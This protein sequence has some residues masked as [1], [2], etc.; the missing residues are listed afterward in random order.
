MTVTLEHVAKTYHDGANEI[1][2]VR[3]ASLRIENGKFTII[4]GASG[5]GK[6]TLLNLIG[7]IDRPTSGKIC[8]GD[9]DVCEASDAELDRVRARHIGY[10]FQSFNLIPVL[11]VLENVEF[12][13]RKTGLSSQKQRSAALEMLDAVGL[14]GLEQKRPNQLSGGQRQRVAIARALTKRPTVVLA[15]EPTANLDSGTGAAILDLMHDLQRSCGIS[16]VFSTHD[17]ALIKRAD[18]LYVIRDG[19]IEVSH[20]QGD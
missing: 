13:L 11:S 9:T 3:D 10:I 14:R 15:D 2:A 12:S 7:C 5:S 8:L 6:S 18:A 1:H 20:N 16:F 19:C 4:T 17:P